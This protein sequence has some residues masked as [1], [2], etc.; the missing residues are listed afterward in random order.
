MTDEEII[1]GMKLLAKTEGIFTETAGGVT[2]GVTKKLIEQGIIPRDE[3]I[4]ISVTGNGLKTQEAIQDRVGHPILIEAKLSDF[5]K[6]IS[7]KRKE[8]EVRIQVTV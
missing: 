7:S 1:E 5:E 2:V 4:L 6:I 8:R 3:S